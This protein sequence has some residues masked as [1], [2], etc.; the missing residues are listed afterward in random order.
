MACTAKVESKA[1]RTWSPTRN[2][3]NFVLSAESFTVRLNAEPWQMGR[4]RGLLF[5]CAQSVTDMVPSS[6]LM[7]SMRAFLS[8]ETE[9]FRSG[10]AKPSARENAGNRMTPNRSVEA[11]SASSFNLILFL[12]RSRRHASRREM[13]TSS[14]PRLFPARLGPAAHISDS[15]EN[16]ITRNRHKTA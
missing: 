11:D 5:N 8:G 15:K 16:V 2:C 10:L 13:Q 3:V 4:E 1:T 9:G 14:V 6:A 7:P 12:L